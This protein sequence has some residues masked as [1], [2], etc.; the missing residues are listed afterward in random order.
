LYITCFIL[1]INIDLI[2][3]DKPNH[4]MSL[5]RINQGPKWIM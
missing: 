2:I 5:Y 1:K 4:I 3:I